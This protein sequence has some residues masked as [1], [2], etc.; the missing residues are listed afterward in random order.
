MRHHWMKCWIDIYSV[1]G[2]CVLIICICFTD[3]FS[4]QLLKICFGTSTYG[5]RLAHFFI[6]TLSFYIFKL[7]IQSFFIS[8]FYIFIYY[9]EISPFTSIVTFISDY[10]LSCMNIASMP[11]LL[12]VFLIPK[13][14]SSTHLCYCACNMSL[15]SSTVGI[16]FSFFKKPVWQALS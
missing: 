1:L 14:C 12:L 9:Y 2:C 8:S 6:Y 11:L 16:F 13:S 3:L 4:N 10:I 15:I 7:C 5:C